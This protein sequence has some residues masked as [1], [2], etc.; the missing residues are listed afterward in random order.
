[1]KKIIFILFAFA[2]I[3]CITSPPVHSESNF[4]KSEYCIQKSNVDVNDILVVNTTDQVLF[5]T[6]NEG[7]LITKVN[8]NSFDYKD[9]W[10]LC[11]GSKAIHKRLCSNI[12]LSNAILNYQYS[13]IKPFLNYIQRGKVKPYF[14]CRKF[15]IN[16]KETY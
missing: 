8:Q 1:M 6:Y 9:Y 16:K 14:L 2:F 11:V 4:V 7:R 10:L 15:L 5:I 13:K 12:S 3:A